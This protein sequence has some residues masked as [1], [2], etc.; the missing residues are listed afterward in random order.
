MKLTNLQ[1]WSLKRW[2]KTVVFGDVM[3]LFLHLQH[4]DA[5]QCPVKLGKKIFL[6]CKFFYFEDHLLQHFYRTGLNHNQKFPDSLL[7][8]SSDLALRHSFQVLHY[9]LVAVQIY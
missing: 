2:S 1:G 8:D 9:L 3:T 4:D 7:V 5:D 6:F